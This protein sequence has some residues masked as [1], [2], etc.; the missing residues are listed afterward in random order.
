MMSGI[1]YGVHWQNAM[2]NGG[3]MI[4]GD[5]DGSIFTDF[6]NGNDVIGHELTHGVTQNSLGLQYTDDAGGL[7]ESISDCFLARMFR[8]WEKGQDVS[9]AL[10]G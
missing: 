6:T 1:H 7:N 8:Q 4:Y 10:I 9:S 3:Q 5:G 2:W